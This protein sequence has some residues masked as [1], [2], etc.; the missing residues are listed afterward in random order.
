LMDHIKEVTDPPA[1]GT[2]VCGK[3]LALVSEKNGE[4]TYCCEHCG[5]TLTVS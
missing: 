4:T 3:P 2:C 5:Q 1:H